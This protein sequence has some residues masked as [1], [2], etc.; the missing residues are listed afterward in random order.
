MHPEF[1]KLPR[2]S[3]DVL[4]QALGAHREAGYLSDKPISTGAKVPWGRLYYGKAEPELLTALAAAGIIGTGA[5][6]VAGKGK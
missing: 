3:F 6:A 1:R 4:Q 5:A 2:M